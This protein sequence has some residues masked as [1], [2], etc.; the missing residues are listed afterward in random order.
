MI[1]KY[2]EDSSQPAFSSLGYFKANLI[3]KELLVPPPASPGVAGH[4]GVGTAECGG[5]HVGAEQRVL[6]GRKPKQ[7]G[8]QPF[9]FTSS[10][11]HR[12][13]NLPQDL[14]PPSIYQESFT[15][16]GMD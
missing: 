8:L 9:F 1:K 2:L 16:S 14:F 3:G 7:I 4:A 15:L 13:P 12:N 5:Q 10:S 6:A 11:Q